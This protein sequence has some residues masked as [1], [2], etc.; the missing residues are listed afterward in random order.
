[1]TI[2]D[3]DAKALAVVHLARG[4][5]TDKTGEAVGVSGRTV[6]R[7]KED[8]EFEAEIEAARRALLN[9]SIAVLTA[10]V[11]KAAE[12]AMELLDDPSPGIRVRA[13]SEVFR[14][15]PVLSEHADLSARLAALEARLD[16]PEGPTWRAA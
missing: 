9:E 7:W 11:R 8:P 4:V 13:V 15:L 6:R 2:P 10:A 12:V 16:D 5:T 14:A 3:L 1:M